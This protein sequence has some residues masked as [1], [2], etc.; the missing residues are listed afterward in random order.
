MH[1][2][3]NA[4]IPRLSIQDLQLPVKGEFWNPIFAQQH[5]ITALISGQT[6]GHSIEKQLLPRRRTKLIYLRAAFIFSSIPAPGHRSFS[7]SLLNGVSTVLRWAWRSS[8]LVSRYSRPVTTSPFAAWWA[9]YSS[10]CTRSVG[11]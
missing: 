4:P 8:E 6:P 2:G 9:T 1:G 11:S 5:H 3:E 7:P 10:A